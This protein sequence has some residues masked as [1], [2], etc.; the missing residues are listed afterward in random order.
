VG[1]G[2]DLGYPITTLLPDGTLLTIYYITFADQVT[3]ISCTRW[4]A[5]D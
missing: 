5:P 3:I 2:S 4:S 1:S